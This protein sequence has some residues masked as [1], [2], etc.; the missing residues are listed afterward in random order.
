MKTTRR[1]FLRVTAGVTLLPAV[2]RIARA[3]TY[4]TRLVRI[5]VGQSAGSGTDTAARLLGHWLSERLGQP[6]T[7]ENQP[8]AGGNLA[9]ANVVR[10]P[11]D[12]STLLAAISA[13]AI[14]QTLYD[15]L[16]FNFVRDI[17]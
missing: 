9:T 4:P 14:N 13:N 11:A 1:Q 12:W 6:F 5:I 8:G 7:I 10:A 16:N 17:T 2:G 3:Q 15:N